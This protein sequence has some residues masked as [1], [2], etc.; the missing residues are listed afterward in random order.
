MSTNKTA[1]VPKLVPLHT[2]ADGGV[3]LLVADDSDE[4]Q[5]ALRKAASMANQNSRHVA[6]L[7]VMEEEAF[8]HWGMIEKRIKKDQR[9]EAE[10]RIW[11][12]ASR[13][14][15]I[16]G[17]RPSLYIKEGKTREAILEVLNTDPNIKMLVLGAGTASSNPL[18]S[19][20]TGKGLS[21]LKVP[22]LVVPDKI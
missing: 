12:V 13:V 8:L 1:E 2:E 20:Y 9:A 17:Q 5:S 6:I 3:Y 19:Y 15:D 7:L 10:K 22:L 4:F 16:S 14:Y 18:V 21:S 11:E